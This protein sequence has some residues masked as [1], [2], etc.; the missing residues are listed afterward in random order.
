MLLVLVNAKYQHALLIQLWLVQMKDFIEL[1]F[2]P[3]YSP[4]LNV[5]EMLWK[6]TRRAVTDNRF[7]EK[8]DDLKYDLQLFWN[9]FKESNQELNY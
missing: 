2:L 5:I 8:L 4:D 6:K 9:N 1:Y 3:P 7:F